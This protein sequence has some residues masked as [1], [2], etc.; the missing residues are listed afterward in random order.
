MYNL[1]PLLNTLSCSNPQTRTP[2][3]SPVSVIQRENPVAAFVT[4]LML[5]KLF[6]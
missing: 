6:L 5:W 1:L 2:A 3:E 4:Q